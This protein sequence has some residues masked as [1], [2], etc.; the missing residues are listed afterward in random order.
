M[1]GELDVCCEVIGGREGGRP[2]TGGVFLLRMGQEAQEERT[3]Q[4]RMVQYMPLIHWQNPTRQIAII[5]FVFNI[6]FV[7]SILECS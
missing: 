5:N 1:Q 2:P 6:N 4:G 7:F 3:A